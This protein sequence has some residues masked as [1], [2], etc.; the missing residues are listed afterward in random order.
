MAFYRHATVAFVGKSLTAIGGQNPIEPAACG[1]PVVFG[2][3]MENFPDVSCLFVNKEA[4]VQVTDA[5]ELERVL[6]E[7][8]ADP[9]RRERMGAAA[10]ELVR[11]NQGAVARTADLILDHLRDAELYIAPQHR[12]E[13]VRT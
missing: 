13:E 2:P 1:K 11:T 4:A 5:A 9:A 8:L 10:L 12:R 3:H 7:L 6:G